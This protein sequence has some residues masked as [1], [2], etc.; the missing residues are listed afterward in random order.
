MK[1]RKTAALPGIIMAA[2]A[3]DDDADLGREVR[4]YLERCGYIKKNEEGK[5]EACKS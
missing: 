3:I 2:C 5:Y 4:I 1:G